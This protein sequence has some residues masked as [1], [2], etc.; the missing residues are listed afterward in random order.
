[1]KV[2]E[3][4][5]IGPGPG[6]ILAA[7]ARIAGVVRRTPLERSGWLSAEAGCDVLLKLECWQPTRSFKVRGAANALTLRAE[8]ARACGVVTASAGN[9]GQAVARAAA[10]V[11]A[12]ATVFVP[13]DAP[14]AKKARIRA[15]GAVLDERERTY[16]DAEVAAAAFAART[17]ALLVHAFS[18]ADVVAGQ[19]TVGVEIAEDLPDV[20]SVVV[21]VGGGGLFAG[22]AIAL[23]AA[24]PAARVV[25]VQSVET[26]AMFD[27][28]AA[29]GVV[30]SPITPTLADGLAGCTDAASY[31]RVRALT[32][33]IHL[34][35]E[36]AIAD[37]M[38]KLFVHDG[39]VAEGAGAAG[40]AA[41]AAGIVAVDGPAVVI[42]T[43]GN[44]DA[45]RYARILRG[46]PWRT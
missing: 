24:A 43:G 11:G 41:V 29:G 13:A 17:G 44:V 39:V 46:E 45:E 6:D 14:A 9:H 26:R 4:E 5:V 8:A 30:A 34:V 42:V 38:R 25:G 19:G 28:F 31:Q 35:D 2:A 23:R 10:A 32:D 12:A 15:L 36:V 3:P 21:P 37:A 7:H 33:T 1:M 40:A 22:V 16:D 20:R 18:D 27:A